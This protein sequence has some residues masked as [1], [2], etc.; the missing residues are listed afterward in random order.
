MRVNAAGFL[1]DWMSILECHEKIENLFLPAAA[2]LPSS[3]FL[4][5]EFKAQA[6]MVSALY[7]F[8]M[9][10]PTSAIMPTSKMTAVRA[11]KQRGSVP[12]MIE[13]LEFC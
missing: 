10:R 3:M 8:L 12:N 2:L 6:A 4:H 5:K 9:A 11:I 13:F 7:G 1:D